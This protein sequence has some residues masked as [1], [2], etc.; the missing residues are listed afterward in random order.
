M[1]CT[2]SGSGCRGRALY[3]ERRCSTHPAGVQP[4][5]YPSNRQFQPDRSCA[6][7]SLRRTATSRA[8]AKS[9]L[10]HTAMTISPDE[11]LFLSLGELKAA[12]NELLHRRR[13]EGVSV[14]L[15]DQA[16]KFIA[17]ARASGA[18]FDDDGD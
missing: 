1:G 2:T 8:A 9:H 6:A 13:T 15:L 14:V 4:L 11:T 16:A 12:H 3:T 17:L 18:F 5:S 7:R 10:E